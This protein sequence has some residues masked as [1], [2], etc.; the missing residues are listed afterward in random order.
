MPCFENWQS[1]EKMRPKKTRPKIGVFSFTSCEGCQL[2]VLSLER[3]FALL[4]ELLEIVNFREATSLRRGDY[5]IA[6]IEGSI[7]RSSEIEE[8]RRIRAAA[9]TLVA[10]G[11]CA[12][13]GG[14]NNLK[15]LHPKST[16]NAVVY[17]NKV[18]APDTIPTMRVADVVTVDYTLPGCP[19]DKAEFVRFVQRLLI[20]IRPRLLDTPVCIECRS[21]ANV[22][23]VEEGGWCLGSVARGGCGAICPCFRESCAACR[24]LLEEANIGS[25]KGILAA[26]GL[27]PSDIRSKFELFNALEEF[28]I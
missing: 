23:L 16:W 8:L 5:E 17:G 3:E 20:G 14:V 26:R 25:L 13:L 19:I 4:V 15:N 1:I 22:C 18:V 21:K 27:S 7:T 6:F 11:A 9:A 2:Q 10:F 28:H 24:G 12:H